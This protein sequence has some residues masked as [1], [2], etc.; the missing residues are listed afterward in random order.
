MTII[1][2]FFSPGRAG[3]SIMMSPRGKCTMGAGNALSVIREVTFIRTNEIR[4]AVLMRSS[5]F[6]VAL[7]S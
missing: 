1:G 2:Y 5:A 7:S 4:S 6:T 3:W